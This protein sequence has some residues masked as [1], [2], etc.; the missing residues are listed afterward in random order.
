MKVNIDINTY[1]N[2]FL[3]ANQ[4]QY[5]FYVEFVFPGQVNAI[6]ASVTNLLASGTINAQAGLE[7]TVGGGAS[8]IDVMGLAD[9]TQNFGYYVKSTSLPSSDIDNT[10]TFWF[11]QEFKTVGT[12]KF[13]DWTVTLYIDDSAMVLKKFY[14]WQK[15]CHNPAT[16]MYGDPSIY[17][18]NQR[19]HLLGFET[20]KTICCYNLYGAWP[21]SLQSIQMDYQSNEFATVDIIFAYQY[22]TITDK[23]EILGAKTGVNQYTQSFLNNNNLME[24]LK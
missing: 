1:K 20:G 15:I 3:G 12:Q 22:F 21:K 19:L 5:L 17:M 11:G 6:K 4:R 7:A 13:E 8:S 2:K 23:E 18:A 24:I 14:E 9:S 10:S 16:N